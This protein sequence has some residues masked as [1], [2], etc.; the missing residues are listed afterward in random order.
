MKMSVQY[1]H[2]SIVPTAPALLLATIAGDRDSNTRAF[3]VSGQC[4]HCVI[5]G[6]AGLMDRSLSG[7]QASEVPRP[8]LRAF[9]S[10]RVAHIDSYEEMED[11]MKKGMP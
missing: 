10:L 6:T 4:E 9:F 1:T 2:S 5:H 7:Q 8:C 11:N 3:R